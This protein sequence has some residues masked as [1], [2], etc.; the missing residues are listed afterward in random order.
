MK[1]LSR[2]IRKSM[3]WGLFLVFLL[4]T[5]F[6]LAK[7][8]GYKL[9]RI[10]DILKITQ[11]GGI[12]IH[13][14]I[15]NAR[16][17]IDD[18]YYENNGLLIRNTLIQKLLPDHQY[19]IVIQKDGFNDWRKK[20]NVYPS[21]VTEARVLMLP[22]EIQKTPLLD[23]DY[24]YDLGFDIDEEL[25]S[26]EKTKLIADINLANEKALELAKQKATTVI[27][28][29]KPIV[30]TEDPKI[31]IPDYFARFGVID[32]LEL[33]NLIYNN[34]QVGWIDNDNIIINWTDPKKT[35]PYYFCLEWNVCRES[36]IVDW[37]D[38]ILAFDYLP[39]RDDVLIILVKEGLFAV[40]IDDR[41]E[42]NIQ[43]IYL[44]ENIEFK[45]NNIGKIVVSDSGSFYQLEL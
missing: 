14:N 43:P 30:E 13:S 22:Q 44:G 32:P 26:A 36:I 39:G 1:P 18:K 19:E 9:D 42:R 8:F 2:K 3:F 31:K 21:V 27:T 35:I 20:L 12:Y 40:E 38:E 29:E 15:S 4:I 25:L 34:D 37:G 16:I 23:M 45:K 10:D 7:S 24:L 5:P 6:I 11:T 41:S 17:Y 33:K 28:D